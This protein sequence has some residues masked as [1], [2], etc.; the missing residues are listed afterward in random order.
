MLAK[1]LGLAAGLPEPGK[2]QIQER[3]LH[4]SDRNTEFLEFSL[5]P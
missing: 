1:K 5:S 2:T 3:T 4:I